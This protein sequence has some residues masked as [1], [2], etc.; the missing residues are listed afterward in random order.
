MWLLKGK[1]EM[2]KA[3]RSTVGKLNLTAV[4]KR[5]KGS[6][7]NSMDSFGEAQSGAKW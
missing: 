1:L 7:E 5:E 3:F 2:E 4:P 6:Q